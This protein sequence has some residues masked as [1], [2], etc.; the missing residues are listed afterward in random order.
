MPLRRFSGQFDREGQAQWSQGSLL[1]ETLFRF[2]GQAAP[3]VVLCEIDFT[4]LDAGALRRLFVGMTRAQWRLVCVLS[5]PAAVLLA[6]RIDA[7]N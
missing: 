6:E 2:K 7:D 3:I 4:T 1:A 5:Q